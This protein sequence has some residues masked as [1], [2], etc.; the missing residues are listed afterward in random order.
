MAFDEMIKLLHF[1][2]HQRLL[3]LLLFCG[4][5]FYLLLRRRYIAIKHLKVDAVRLLGQFSRLYVVQQSDVGAPGYVFDRLYVR[6]VTNQL[7]ERFY[8]IVM[9][10]L[11][12][13]VCV[14][15]DVPR[16]V[17]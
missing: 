7:V 16:D 5:V 17:R 2:L 4:P 12:S 15:R 9:F 14:I 10:E 11:L 13:L 8:R 1:I 3:Q 6:R